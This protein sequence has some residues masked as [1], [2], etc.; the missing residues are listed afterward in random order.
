MNPWYS[1]RNTGILQNLFRATPILFEA[2]HVEFRTSQSEVHEKCFM[3]Y[4]IL[5]TNSVDYL[6]GVQFVL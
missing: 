2:T 1:I 3:S 5:N 4:L 6:D